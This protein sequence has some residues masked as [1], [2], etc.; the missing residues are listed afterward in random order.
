MM[1]SRNS[2]RGLGIF[3]GMLLAAAA[4]SGNRLDMFGV[5]LNDRNNP[6]DDVD[7]VV[8][9]F[10]NKRL[11]PWPMYLFVDGQFNAIDPAINLNAVPTLEVMRGVN[12][13]VE[14]W[15]D[16]SISSFRFASGVVPIDHTFARF[17]NQVLTPGATG[18]D[19]WNLITFM[20]PIYTPTA[21]VVSEGISWKFWQDFDL[22]SFIN[23]PGVVLIVDPPGT[24]PPGGGTPTT[25]QIDFDLD[26][27]PDV[28]IEA[29]KYSAG[30][31]IE[32]DI[33]MSSV[34]AWRQWPQNPRDLPTSYTRTQTLG[35]LDIQGTVTHEL[36]HAI[37]IAH[38]LIEKATMYYAVKGPYDQGFRYPTDIWDQ[39]SLD[40]D[41]EISVGLIYP[42]NN[43]RRGSIT[44]R[45]LDGRNFDGLSDLT[46]GV[47]DPV[48]YATFYVLRPMTTDLIPALVP[49][50]M[51]ITTQ[52][53]VTQ[54][55]L[56]T[57][58]VLWFEMLAQIQSGD[59]IQMARFPNPLSLQHPRSTVQNIQ[60]HIEAS[61][62]YVIPGLPPFDRYVLYMEDSTTYRNDSAGVATD[63]INPAFN[64][65][66]AFQ[67]IP[68]EFYGGSANPTVRR[69][70]GYDAP[71]P[72]RQ[73]TTVPL[74]LTGDD[75]TSYVY[76]AVRAGEVTSGIDMYTNT[77]G[78]PAG[79][80]PTPIPGMTPTPAP[81]GDTRF[82]ADAANDHLLPRSNDWTVASASGDIDNDGDIDLY[83]CNA[84]SSG[85]GGSPTSIV[86][87]L[88]VN[89]LWEPG[90]NPPATRY[91][92]A[93]SFDG[94][95]V[96]QDRTFGPDGVAGTADDR[97]PFNLDSSFHAKMADFNLDGFPD[98]FVCNASSVTDPNF[99]QNRLFL[100]RGG[101]N[102]AQ[103]GWFDDVTSRTRTDAG[104]GIPTWFTNTIIPGRLNVAPFDITGIMKST[105]CD[106]GDIDSDGDI[107]IIV[108]TCTPVMGFG[109]FTATNLCAATTNNNQRTAAFFVTE[110]ILINHA[111]DFDP[112]TR[113]FYFTDETLGLDGQWG[114]VLDTGTEPWNCA[115]T[116]R[117]AADRLPPLYPF[118]ATGQG[119]DIGDGMQV[120]IAPL[121]GNSSLDLFVV[122]DAPQ[123]T[124]ANP[125]P[126]YLYENADVDGDGVADGYF[127][128]CNYGT[129]EY[130]RFVL[131]GMG[132]P[133]GPSGT[134]PTSFARQTL[135]GTAGLG[136]RQNDDHTN[137]PRP[138][139][140]AAEPDL[141]PDQQRRGAGGV[142][143]DFDYHGYPSVL[144]LD[145]TQGAT[146]YQPQALR[147]SAQYF[148]VQR[149]QYARYAGFS[150]EYGNEMDW[151]PPLYYGTGIY[152]WNPC[153]ISNP[154]SSQGIGNWLARHAVVEDFDFD[155]DPDVYVCYEKD[156]AED[157]FPHIPAPNEYFTNDGFGN[158]RNDTA[159]ATSGTARG[160]FYVESFDFDGDGDPDIFQSNV[161]SQ[162]T[163]ILNQVFHPAEYTATSNTLFLSAY[164]N[165]AY[166]DA[167]QFFLPP[168]YSAL[169]APPYASDM[170]KLS[171]TSTMG[172][173]TGDGLPEIINSN[174]AIASM[175]GDAS[176]LLI[177]HGKPANQGQKVFA[178]ISSAG[179]RM[180]RGYGSF[181]SVLPGRT[182]TTVTV[183][184]DNHLNHFFPAYKALMAD[185]DLDGDYDVIQTSLGAGPVIYSNEDSA[186]LMAIN[187]S[188]VTERAFN[189]IPDDD[190]LGDGIL[191]PGGFAAGSFSSSLAALPQLVDPGPS[192]TL[193]KKRQNRR[194]AV[195][196]LDH[197]GTIDVVIACGLPVLQTP[198]TTQPVGG[199]PNVLLLNGRPP[200]PIGTFLDRTEQRLPTRTSYYTSGTTQVPF[201][202]GINDDTVDVAVADFD[203]DSFLEII[204]LNMAGQGTSSTR[205]LDCVNNSAGQFV[206]FVDTPDPATGRATRYLP[207]FAGRTPTRILVA[208]F[209]RK[210]DPTEDING[211]GVL[212]PGEDKNHNGILDWWDTTETEDINGNGVLDPG[213]DGLAPFGASQRHHQ[214]CRPER[215]WRNH[216]AS[217][218]HI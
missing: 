176:D 93:R 169:T 71:E 126:D 94:K 98:I 166:Y 95:P 61:P 8:H 170:A 132:G 154:L 160:T 38:S 122:R 56:D 148:G 212:D 43:P 159:V 188:G 107:D 81:V 79:V 21:A 92:G 85:A 117:M 6:F 165:P 205:L 42:K 109:A 45:I 139:G 3:A 215:R 59:N 116:A 70:L 157:V 106:V 33:W 24:N 217:S 54:Y 216:T 130:G 156:R 136:I 207:D 66:G 178:P 14:A 161:N 15:N 164:D 197:N 138:S 196:D 64:F 115:T 13:A 194:A 39:R 203:N 137:C 187:Y 210:G 30:E 125:P 174:G 72:L 102:P 60:M 113:G 129:W 69:M 22:D 179:P 131:M 23:L 100:N 63:N 213:E 40:L 171:V 168:Y 153:I 184:Y 201:Q 84:V 158:F 218:G 200:Y 47:I 118:L 199:A 29:R 173:L 2:V 80:T 52:T 108:A 135:T 73:V 4:W 35:T 144:T 97:L 123:F 74:V 124:N 175:S 103:A 152:P 5:I 145:F 162:S 183:T 119:E 99:A 9:P 96:F 191:V 198:G 20:D 114:E 44:G 121:V 142:A 57:S 25:A 182:T 41:D 111:N 208:D 211:N 128:Q 50:K 82:S 141:I 10:I 167:S 16:V 11:Q 46:S 55:D 19:G 204:F 75:P 51:I 18:L 67:P 149:L 17:P 190:F 143:F 1:K 34:D 206:R 209:D 134:V 133:G 140:W 31:I 202:E 193:V 91:P 77:G 86:N 49:D 12:K 90:A 83:I 120:I 192:G 58:P 105:K 180:V 150:I 76:V 101:T 26:G 195:G 88:Y 172:D 181:G 110:Q 37:G 89:T 127:R 214:R 62:Q 28:L 147:N 146:L 7:V 78:L 48:L 185:F 53:G 186:D 163:I 112:N 151:A 189:S 68:A 177:N 36:G 32:T 65:F 87:R 155:G 104:I 27:I